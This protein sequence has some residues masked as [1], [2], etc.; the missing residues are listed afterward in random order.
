MMMSLKK[1]NEGNLGN[2]MCHYNVIVAVDHRKLHSSGIIG[3]KFVILTSGT[4]LQ[5]H[6]NGSLK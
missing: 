6:F 2:S 4:F 1:L 3:D 5:S